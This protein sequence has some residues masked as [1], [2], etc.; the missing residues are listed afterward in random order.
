MR[1]LNIRYDKVVNE[2]SGYL[3]FHFEYY[4]RVTWHQIF[5]LIKKKTNS[6]LPQCIRKCNMIIL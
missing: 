3:S 1:E 2:Q 4:E 6:K 5:F